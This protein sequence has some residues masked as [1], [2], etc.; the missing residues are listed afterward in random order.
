M[1]PRF[2]WV[3]LIAALAFATRGCAAENFLAG[4]DMS[5]LAF[6]ESNGISYKT[7]GQS[8]DAISILKNQGINCVRLRLFTSSA[9]QAQADL[10]ARKTTG[11]I[12]LEP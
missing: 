5:L 10:E 1:I 8:S 9:A 2:S 4:A 12:L 7:N 6:F 3:L 11:K